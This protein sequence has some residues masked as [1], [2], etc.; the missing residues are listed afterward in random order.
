MT[1]TSERLGGSRPRGLARQYLHRGLARALRLPPPTTDYSVRCGVRVPMRD[2]VE[3][4]ADHYAPATAT[5]CG[6]LLV[7]GPYGRAFPFSVLFARLYAARGY[8]VVLQSV[9]GTFGSGAVFEPMI[10][11]AADGSDTVAWLRRQC[12]FTGRFATVGPSYLGFTQWALLQDPPPEMAAAVITVGPHD[13]SAASW[14]TGAFTLNDYLGWCDLVAHQEDGSRLRAGIRQIGARR[15]LA[16][17]TAA[18]PLGEAGRALLGAGAP[19]YEPWLEH[20]DRDDPFWRRFRFDTALERAEVPVL[21]IGGWQDI[22]LEQTLEQYGRLRRRGADVALTVG[23]WTHTQMM[24]SGAGPVARASLQWLDTHLAG[25]APADRDPVRI[26]VTG[27]RWVDLTDWPPAIDEQALYPWPGGALA[28]WPPGDAARPSVFRFDPADPT[29]TIGGRLLSPDG[30]SRNDSR[31]AQR[32]DVLA[33][34]G[35]P[36]GADLYVLGRPVVELAHAADIPHVD[37]FVRV[38]EVDANGRSRN[39]VDGYR[40]LIGA[41]EPNIVRIELDSTAHRFRAGSRIRLLV[42][43]GCHPR[44]ARNLGTGEPVVTG[45]RMVSA[46]HRVHHGAGGLSRL[47]LPASSSP[48]SAQPRRDRGG[49]FG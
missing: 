1:T 22:F 24:L 10:N 15:R 30:G 4:L 40:R 23:P 49:D 47:M 7:R 8:H 38:S 2:G 9:R 42:A 35:E 28:G 37:L 3:L 14:A 43:G 17:A 21:L 39:V 6:T 19:W 20:P 18:L 46:T 12:W 33:F 36:L 27:D 29:P 34:T 41:A 26:F 16:R 31:L 44:Y 45:R 5:P 25:I 32:H 48:P 11:E 13:F